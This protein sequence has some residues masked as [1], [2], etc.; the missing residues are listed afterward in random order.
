MFNLYPQA[1]EVDA[2]MVITTLWLGE[3]HR[4][5]KLPVQSHTG[6][7]EQSLSLRQVV[8]HHGVFS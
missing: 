1:C 4:E 3:M 2:I 8:W 7:K 6:N 5:V